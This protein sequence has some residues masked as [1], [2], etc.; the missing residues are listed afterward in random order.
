LS[1]LALIQNQVVGYSFQGEDY[2]TFL[3]VYSSGKIGEIGSLG[4]KL[5]AACAIND[6]GAIAGY[7][8]DSNGNLQAFSYSDKSGI[9]SLGTFDGGSTSEAFGIN[10]NNSSRWHETVGYR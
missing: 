5:K 3:Y 8:Q 2:K 6:S 9:I 1:I 10:D 7:S 4:G